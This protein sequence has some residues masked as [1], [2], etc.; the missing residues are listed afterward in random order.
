MGDG[1]GMRILRD[2]LLM[3]IELTTVINNL[4]EQPVLEAPGKPLTLRIAIIHALTT[5]ERGEGKQKFDRYEL[6][7]KIKRAGQSIDLTAEEVVTIKECVGKAYYP[8]VVGPVFN[9]LDPKKK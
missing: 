3:K 8:V 7:V 1:K 6:A 9:L 4:D 5:D 2:S